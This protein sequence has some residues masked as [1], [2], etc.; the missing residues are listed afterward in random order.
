M[1]NVRRPDEERAAAQIW[2][3]QHYRA[4]ISASRS[5]AFCASSLIKEA[6]QRVAAFTPDNSNSEA[7]IRRSC[8]SS[9]PLRR[10]S[11]PRIA[12]DP[13]TGMVQTDTTIRHHPWSRPPRD[14]GLA[15]AL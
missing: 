13:S 4:T 5:L 2:L 14:I 6:D 8:R 9:R 15:E 3:P 1:T 12:G 11:Q 10:A 7:R